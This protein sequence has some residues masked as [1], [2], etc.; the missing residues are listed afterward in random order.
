[1]SRLISIL[2]L[3]IVQ[4]SSAISNYHVIFH[5][6]K[7]SVFV[8][9]QP[10]VCEGTLP[11]SQDVP[12]RLCNDQ[13][14]YNPSFV[15][16]QTAETSFMTADLDVAD[17]D[18]LWSYGGIITRVHLKDSH[19]IVRYVGVESTPPTLCDP[20][21]NVDGP[22]MTCKQNA[23]TVL[24]LKE[25]VID[26]EEDDY[27]VQF[28]T[29]PAVTN[30]A[31]TVAFSRLQ[32]IRDHYSARIKSV[33]RND[34]RRDEAQSV[35]G[36]MYFFLVVAILLWIVLSANV[37]AWVLPIRRLN[38]RYPMAR[39][40]L[41]W[42]AILV[43][44]PIVLLCTVG[45]MGL[46]AWITFITLF[47]IV[48]AILYFSCWRV[49]PKTSPPRIREMIDLQMTPAERKALRDE[50][51]GEAVYRYRP[52]KVSTIQAKHNGLLFALYII[53]ILVVVTIFYGWK[54]NKYYVWDRTQQLAVSDPS[55]SLATKQSLSVYAFDHLATFLEMQIF[56][57]FATEICETQY[58]SKLSSNA[59][60]KQA[61]FDNFITPYDV[62]M[63][64][65]ERSDF[66]DYNSVNDWLTRRLATGFES[67]IQTTSPV[68]NV[69]ISPV[70]GKAVAFNRVPSDHRFWVK[71]EDFSI[72]DLMGSDPQALAFTGGTVFVLR[73]SYQDYHRF[74]SPFEGLISYLGGQIGTKLMGR[75]AVAVQSQNNVLYNKRRVMVINTQN[76]GKIAIVAVGS[77]CAGSVHVEV[78]SGQAVTKGQ[79]LGHFEFGGSTVVMILQ[80]DVVEI[81]KDLRQNSVDS[82]ETRV[83]FGMRLGLLR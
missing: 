2:A 58:N 64:K 75:S 68:D 52:Y 32:A 5:R 36:L 62:D 19:P 38:P 35:M 67:R 47:D 30:I 15:A 34:D 53:I 46:C 74:H 11:S 44:P 31:L 50:F 45:L 43:I 78:S 54:E 82:F 27:Q 4:Y 20:V 56:N 81:D 39:S 37:F 65:Y 17:Y 33:R 14:F 29:D 80:S 8:E 12:R 16:Q 63:T 26:S 79:E 49:D 72:S 24:T 28:S 61:I 77:T 7:F 41:T 40:F 60:K 6:D 42:M 71:D 66:R 9:G 22:V 73:L 18:Q 70:Y 83:E 69:L 57:Q 48:V 23:T 59:D 76:Y 10:I 25:A 55:P 21:L 51:R 3:A 13:V 1:M